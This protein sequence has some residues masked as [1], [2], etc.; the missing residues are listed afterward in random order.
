M[1]AA[2]EFEIIGRYFAGQRIAHRETELG[3]GD[4]CAV[5]KFVAETRLALTTDTLV[6]GVH[7]FSD[8]DPERLGHKALAV[9]LSDL[10]A[11]GARPQW[12]LLALTLPESDS[13]WLSAFARGF[14]RLAERY[15]VQLIGGDTTRGPLAVTVQALGML[16]GNTAIARSGAR[17]G[18]SVYVT[19]SLGLAGLGLKLK[20]G[21]AK[22]WDRAALDKLETPEP[23]VGFGLRL[24]EFATACIDISDG[25]AADLGHIL[26]QSGVAAEVD[27]ELLP[28]SPTV[29]GYLADTGDWDLPLSAGDD[30]ELCFTAPPGA[31]QAIRRAAEATG[32]PVSR[33]GT[34][35][36]GSGLSLQRAGRPFSLSRP[37]YLHFSA[38][39]A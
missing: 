4:D 19:G 36:P 20:Q 18:D 21:T 28:L 37:G 9:N 11:M 26:E 30:Y 38:G 12:A 24:H 10:A 27:C 15:G 5:L 39:E 31:D 1:Q 13:E 34:I 8:A 29:R 25:L 6:A 22:A 17:P 23:R 16:A 7:F 3:I 2:G 14:F 35:L 32:V 33:I